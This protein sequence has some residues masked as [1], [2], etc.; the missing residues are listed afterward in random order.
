[1]A[2]FKSCSKE[3]CKLIC[4]ATSTSPRGN[5][6]LNNVEAT[7]IFIPG[8]D[9]KHIK[10]SASSICCSSSSWCSH[11]Y[12]F[13]CK[14]ISPLGWLFAAQLL[15]TPPR[16]CSTCWTPKWICQAPAGLEVP[17][18]NSRKIHRKDRG[19]MSKVLWLSLVDVFASMCIAC[20]LESTKRYKEI[21]KASTVGCS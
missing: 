6:W 13:F 16:R 2:S 12:P 9:C 3:F 15:P 5:P 1:M 10:P 7:R 21:Q 4:S 8:Y 19:K 11:F 17:A 18:S 20:P 14:Y